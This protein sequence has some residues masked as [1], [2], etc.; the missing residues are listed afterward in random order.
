MYSPRTHHSRASI[1][2]LIALIALITYIAPMSYAQ[3]GRG[4][5][6]GTVTDAG[7]GTIAGAQV[8]I[9]NTATN[10]AYTAVTGAEGFYTVPNLS[11]GSYTVTAT[12]DG[13]KKTVR[14][15]IVLEVDQKAEINVS[16]EAGAVNESVEITAE[17]SLIDT[18][19]ATVGKV[20]ENRR[21][22]ELPV[23]GRNALALVL[24]APSVQSAVGPRATGFA[25][26][27]T[28]VSSIRINGSPIATNNFIVDG[29]SSVNAYLPD[30]NINPTVDAVQ[31][32]KVMTNT[33]SSEFGFTL[34]GVV[35]LVTKS[36]TNL[37][38]G[39]LYEFFRND[40]LDSNFWSNNRASRPKQ[41]LRYNQFGGAV[42]GP[43]R[44]PK[45]F[46]P[47]GYDGR[48]RS[49]FF[50]NYEGYRFITS[51]SGF[52]TL[53]TEAFRR[54]NFS[55]L[56]NDQG[57]LITIYD[58]ATTRPNPNYDP[59]KVVTGANQP[60]LRDPF[61]GNII[62]ENR[63]DPVAK[64]ILQFYPLPNRAPDNQFSNLNNYYGAVSNNRNLNQYTSRVDHRFN[65]QNNFSAR[66]T[67]YRQ[68]TDQGLTNLYPDPIVR[69]RNDP[70][71]GHNIV[72]EDIQSF[73]P[74]LIHT[75][76]FGVARQSF[77][78]AVAS[79]DQDW[80]GQL[81]LP[82]SVPPDTFP[83]INNGL[84]AFNSGVVGVRGGT[85][86]QL[87][88]SLTLLKGNHSFKF[89]T[90]L[91][92]IQAN[93]LQKGSPSGNF[94][95]PASLTTNAVQTPGGDANTGSQFASFLLGGVGRASVTTHLGESEVGKSYSFF[96]QDDWKATRRLTLNLGVRYDYQQMPYER[97]C[98][99]SNFD[100]FAINPTNGLPGMTEYACLD[101]GRT[102]M[103]EDRDDF[104][105]RI[106]FALDIFGNQ[107]MVL[108]GGY[109]IFY[110]AVWAFYNNIYGSV[111]GFASTTTSYNPPS[112]NELF[113]AFQLKDGFPFIPNQ[114]MGSRLGPNLFAT[115]S[116]DYQEAL[117]ST[118]MSQQWNLSVQHQLPAGILFEATYSGNHGTHLFAGTYNL[119]QTDPALTA[120]YGLQGRLNEQVTNPYAGKVPGQFGGSKITLAQSLRPYPY[121]GDINVRN[122]RLGNSIYHALL[123][124]GE[125]RF[126]K[127]FAFL[128]S[129]TFGKLISDS[130]SNPL[131]FIT[132]EGAGE[133][134]YQNGKYNR[135]AERA[136][137]PS[138]VPHRFV[139]S[140]LWELPIGN[141]RK[142][143]FRNSALNTV[144]GNWQLN[145][146]TTI[147]SGTPL[148]V[149]GGT[150][151]PLNGLANRPN[152]ASSPQRVQDG[153][154]DPLN[155]PVNDLG[156][157]WFDP[158]TFLNPPDYTYG[159]VSRSLSGIRNPG[160]FISDLSIFKNFSITEKVKIQLRVE[161][162]NFL[163]HTNLLGPNVTFGNN[164]G[165]VTGDGLP[166]SVTTAGVAT[167]T[168]TT[169]VTYGDYCRG[170]SRTVKLNGTDTTVYRNQCNTNASFGRILTARDPRQMQFGLKLTF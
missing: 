40:A 41:P 79:A 2:I 153:F 11:V 54:G 91:R 28:E 5:I 22:Q 116:A 166:V 99:T 48:D 32:F 128:A 82:P 139:F 26:R 136:E 164:A 62:P 45:A 140:G 7:G 52:Y 3:Q 97:R 95:F 43:I 167:I 35:N 119:N 159:N 53:P 20:I 149:R 106:G 57:T 23:N 110:P 19:T 30:V 121:V 63:I 126:S 39:S 85:V 131:N 4:T 61:P 56:R 114:P 101:Y 125:K 163:N 47:L 58:P 16:L 129:Y 154:V 71:R 133:F 161:A 38:H 8:T 64:N 70:F 73:T 59:N 25:D 112:N 66:Y 65:E 104:S 37:Y 147:V 152:L 60:Y 55:Q 83:L 15:G 90:E 148:V 51:T 31:E 87:F 75:I 96:F 27:G 34:G 50:F 78:F 67:F 141:S 142:L 165:E 94:T 103:Q 36:G 130:I 14:N 10:L 137:D 122:P 29:L 80:P 100:P 117:G 138:N 169:P 33:M 88:D 1:I 49:F 158:S 113:S 89:G 102:A 9:T 107:K 109:S 118:P 46:G 168:R 151:T 6:Q 105:P 134:G 162:F 98:G 146:V 76:R 150:G 93:N 123:L 155:V 145:T 115:S 156:V 77:T 21:V 170:K 124:S 120:L 68:F 132:T 17:A 84:P 74:S 127:G 157:L 108:R 144:L 13:F 111:N 86:W 12:K 160:A 69:L 143:D 81:G 135:A 44:L 92:L 18:A 24:L 72:L 42:G